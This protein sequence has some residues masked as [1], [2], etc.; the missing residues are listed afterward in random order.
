MCEVNRSFVQKQFPNAA[1][2]DI[3]FRE[4]LLDGHRGVS[5]VLMAVA[6]GLRL[7]FKGQRT[8]EAVCAEARGDVLPVADPVVV[9]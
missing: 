3:R 8:R 1:G 2:A 6:L 9:E 5:V 7:Q 4:I